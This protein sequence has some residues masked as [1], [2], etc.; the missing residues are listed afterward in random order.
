LFRWPIR[1]SVLAAVPF[2][3]LQGRCGR[4]FGLAAQ[5][6]RLA[7]ERGPANPFFIASAKTGIQSASI[8]FGNPHRSQ[9]FNSRKLSCNRSKRWPACSATIAPPTGH[10][11]IR[12]VAPPIRTCRMVRL[13][14]SN[15]RRCSSVCLAAA[16]RPFRDV[17][18]C[19]TSRSC[20]P[21]APRLDSFRF[22]TSEPSQPLPE[23]APGRRW[24]DPE[25][26]EFLQ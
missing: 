21:R 26:Q 22:P 7:H 23:N 11:S 8:P 10:R 25:R 20:H 16:E 3:S 5:A 17:Q 1:A 24:T 4:P 6:G 15:S 13:F 19:Q 12:T 2:A 18:G 14:R 9:A